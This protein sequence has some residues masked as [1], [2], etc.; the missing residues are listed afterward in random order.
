MCL[1][2][3]RL[4]QNL[5]SYR[6]DKKKRVCL[7]IIEEMRRPNLAVVLSPLMK[8]KANSGKHLKRR[9]LFLKQL[10]YFGTVFPDPRERLW[11]VRLASDDTSRQPLKR[12]YRDGTVSKGGNVNYRLS[13]LRIESYGPPARWPKSSSRKNKGTGQA[14]F[15]WH[16]RERHGS[17][18]KTRVPGM[19]SGRQ[20]LE[21]FASARVRSR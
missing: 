15:R 8:R 19:D 7:I 5:A 18:I 1:F 2:M 21:H 11:Q 3:I 10:R 12:N 17:C 14:L 9:P 6:I 20:N 16:A 4:L 13:S